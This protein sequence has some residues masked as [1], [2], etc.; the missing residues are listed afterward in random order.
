MIFVFTLAAPCA[1]ASNTLDMRKD[2]IALEQKRK[3]MEKLAQAELDMARKEAEQK[4]LAIKNDQKALEDKI[5]KLKTANKRLKLERES[6]EKKLQILEK[7]GQA[8]KKDLAE[9]V[10]E[11]V[12]LLDIVRSFAKNSEILLAQSQQS[13]LIKDRCNFLASMAQEEIFPSMDDIR[14]MAD[15]FFQE[16]QASGAVR[17]TRG[18]I[19]DRHGVEQEADILLLGNF[20]GFY[21]MNSLAGEKKKASEIGFLLYSEK[22]RRFF[23]LS[24]LPSSGMIK[25]IKGYINGQRPDV[26]VDIS[27]G[28]ALR[29]F[30]HKLDLMS[31]IKNGGPLVWPILSILCLA[32]IILF[33]RFVF[34]FSKQ[35]KMKSFMMKI[36]NLITR[37][38]WVECEK[39]LE[40][41]KKC[42]IP[43]VLLKALPFRNQSRQDMENVLQEAIL[44]EIPGIERFLSTL[45]ILAAIAPLMGLLGTVTGMINTF[46]VITYYGAGDPKMMS[47]GISEALVTTMLGLSVAIPIMLFYTLLNRRVELLISGMEEKAVAFVN[48][49]FKTRSEPVTA[50]KNKTDL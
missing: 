32:L 28:E 35:V 4:A 26:P 10:S 27:R 47:S 39:L 36:E 15:L 31:Q 42:L 1:M 18:I 14:K 22:S 6:F 20:T 34:F 25:K 19:V 48:M 33:E 11:N 38:E 29:R 40:S 49:I 16:I 24:R 45:G 12:Y 7:N 8:L 9:I 44:S 13:G 5:N 21:I 50:G 46:H 17:M 37:E 2:H 23:A 41:E 3:K 30:T 43:K